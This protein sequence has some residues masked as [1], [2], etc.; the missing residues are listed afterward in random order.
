MRA[1]GAQEIFQH[2]TAAPFV[3]LALH[4]HSGAFRDAWQRLGIRS[5]SVADRPTSSPPI[6]PS[7]H[8]IAD[9]PTWHSAYKWSIPLATANPDCHC[10]TIAAPNSAPSR[11]RR[12]LIAGAMAQAVRHAAWV[13]HAADL[14]AMEQPPTLLEYIIGPPSHRTSLADFGCPRRKAWH[15]WLRGGLLPVPP[16]NPLPEGPQ[17]SEHHALD[18]V[19]GLTHE[20]LSIARA[21]TP[22]ALADAHAKA[23]LPMLP[24]PR[25]LTSP[26]DPSPFHNEASAAGARLTMVAAARA[27]PRIIPPL[28]SQ[29][30]I[31]IPVAAVKGTLL[32]LIPDGALFGTEIRDKTD[33]DAAA[34]NTARA[35]ACTAEPLLAHTEARGT[36]RHYVYA[37]PPSEL[38]RATDLSFEDVAWQRPSRPR[39]CDTAYLYV[40]F[41]LHRIRHIFFPAVR[42]AEVIG[43]LGNAEP[44]IRSATASAWQ[45]QPPVRSADERWRALMAR[46]A[47]AATSFQTE[48]R[49][50]DRGDGNMREWAAATRAIKDYGD[51]LVLPPQGR[52]R[53]PAG[54]QWTLLPDIYQ[55]VPDPL[56]LTS[57]MLARLP[58]QALPPGPL[59]THASEILTEW[60]ER[61]LFTS[62]RKICLR[63]AYF[64]DHPPPPRDATESQKQAWMDAAPPHPA[65]FLAGDGAFR[66]IQHADGLGSWRA[67]AVIFDVDPD[68][69]V[70]PMDTTAEPYT[71]WCLEKLSEVFD[72][73]SDLELL[74]HV[75]EGLRYKAPRPRQMRILCN[76]DSLATHVRPIA[77]DISKLAGV[78]MYKVRP[79]VWLTGEWAGQTDAWPIVLARSRRG[80]H[81]WEESTRRTGPTRN[82]G[83]RTGP[84]RTRPPAR[85]T[86]RTTSRA[87]TLH[88][89]CLLYTSPSPRDS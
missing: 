4:E 81:R 1:P 24:R 34:I 77:D 68:G 49:T 38:P 2:L 52:P 45:R 82:V 54:A 3:T 15:W 41:A 28:P 20:L 62:A 11:W 44:L 16:S 23:W 27:C 9:V 8:F 63:E 6:P 58:P 76:M 35:L 51:E 30:V 33:R 17:P 19:P 22:R 47:A 59:P 73:S 75:F 89:S 80:R 79:L 78:G 25:R 85:E 67:N 10:A 37:V 31:V 14:L 71:H 43:T 55:V 74:S 88:A 57:Q 64:F 48:L 21:E 18:D 65:D 83:S 40:A 12:H 26:R 7:N 53:T 69:A 66:L 42:G 32:A 86:T 36:V 84:G 87:T 72:C 5:A 50:L 39:Q 29:T 13:L 61:R 60:C 70:R 46:D 56:P